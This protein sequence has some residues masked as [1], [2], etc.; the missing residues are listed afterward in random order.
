ML[1]YIWVAFFLIAFVIALAKLIFFG[2]TEIFPK[3]IASTFDMAKTGFEISLGLTGVMT[4]WLGLMKIGEKGGAVNLL[5][6]LVSPFFHRL[7]PELPKN[8]PVIGSILMNFSANMLGL[9]N[10]ATPLGLKAMKEMQEL[11]SQKDTASNAQIMFLVLNTSGL[12][13]I[14]LSIMVYRAQMGAEDPSDIFIPILL[15]TFFSTFIGLVTVA[16]YQKINFL[17]KVII[18]YLGGLLLFVLGVIWYFSSLDQAQISTISSVASNLILFSVIIL[19]I[20][21]ALFA[22]VNVY[23]AFIEG[24]KE[25]F[26]TAI[27]IIPYLVA[28]LVAIGVFRT[29]G[30][31]DFLV[32]G[33]KLAVSSLGVNTDFVAGLPTALMKPLSGSGARG[34]MLDAMK[35]YGADSFVGRLVSIIQG[36]TETTFYVLAVYFGSVNIKNTRYAVN[37]GLL[38]DLAG[39]IAAIWLTYLFF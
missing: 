4:L 36:S 17:N 34:M 7:F 39:V 11:N 28:I 10:A 13:I 14:P 6:R 2:D 16:I 29:S 5:A 23:E 35:Q 9:D 15:A 24:A 1:N 37:C 3:L 20:T 25:G 8:H 27:T 26:Q 22:K 33:I 32:D 31:M 18:A 21:L 30:A 12:T 38:A 19:F